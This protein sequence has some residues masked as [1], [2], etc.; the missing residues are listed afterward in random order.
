M[1]F[2]TVVAVA[3]CEALVSLPGYPTPCGAEWQFPACVWG[4]VPR[5]GDA[6]AGAEGSSAGL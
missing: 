4:V 6:G 1:I 5:L 3:K 2:L